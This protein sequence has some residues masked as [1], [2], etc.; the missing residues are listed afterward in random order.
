VPRFYAIRGRGRGKRKFII[1]RYWGFSQTSWDPN[2]YQEKW[3]STLSLYFRRKFAG[4]SH[5]PVFLQITSI[6]RF[7]DF[8]IFR[9]FDFSIFRFFTPCSQESFVFEQNTSW[10]EPKG[11]IRSLSLLSWRNHADYYGRASIC[12]N[13]NLKNKI[14]IHAILYTK[15]VWVMTWQIK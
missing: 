2:L 9:F 12:L 7:F 3:T 1:I 15:K 6:F 11:Q 10:R 13:K 8:S 5:L 14:E 4:T